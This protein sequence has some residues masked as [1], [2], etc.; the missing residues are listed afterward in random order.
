[1]SSCGG[2]KSR[3][4]VDARSTTDWAARSVRS[5]VQG[6][7]TPSWRRIT[8]AGI[9]K[10][11][12]FHVRVV[13]FLMV[14]WVYVLQ[15][16]DTDAIYVGETTRL[17][18]RWHE[19]STGRGGVT[20]SSDNYDTLIGLY[21]VSHNINFL[22]YF[23]D[24]TQHQK[25]DWKL[26][27]YWNDEVDRSLA[28]EVENHI[29]ER[30]SYDGKDVKGGKYCRDG[31]SINTANFTVD[32]PLCKCGLPCEVNL[33]KD[34]TKIYFTCPVPVWVD[35]GYNI[36]EKC[37]FWKEYEQYRTLREEHIQTR[38]Q[39]WREKRLAA[40]IEATKDD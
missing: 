7:A 40:Y 32:R 17:Y 2:H 10:G 4:G 11:Y 5:S 29:T 14:H 22:D 8:E 6:G 1:M 16:S 35:Y 26:E 33:K 18:R 25:H 9:G 12:R 28:L 3:M 27:H 13:L 39:T 24:A 21:N 19:H 15:S 38:R 36:P 37:N 34:K 31:C 20:T 23:K 30:Y